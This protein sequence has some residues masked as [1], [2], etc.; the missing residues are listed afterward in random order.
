M[1]RTNYLTAASEF[2]KINIVH[3]TEYIHSA[4]I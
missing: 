3:R 2:V 4:V 1:K